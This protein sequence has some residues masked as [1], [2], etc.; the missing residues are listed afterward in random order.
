M[1]ITGRNLPPSKRGADPRKMMLQKLMA[2]GGRTL[3]DADRAS[4]QEVMGASGAAGSGAMGA[5]GRDMSDTD[6]AVME[7][8]SGGVKGDGMDVPASDE[9]A[10]MELLLQRKAK[11]RAMEVDAMKSGARG[12]AKGALLRRQSAAWAR[13]LVMAVLWLAVVANIR[14]QNNG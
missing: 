7:A 13:N 12:F 1:A 10:L 11:D 14:G 2:E 8:L 9:E 6:R 5:S 3:S 4:V